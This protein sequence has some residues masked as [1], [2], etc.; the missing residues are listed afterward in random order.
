MILK[1]RIQKKL[2]LLLILS[3][4][5]PAD[6]AFA[7]KAYAQEAEEY[8]QITETAEGFLSEATD[9]AA[10]EEVQPN[11]TDPEVPVVGEKQPDEVT[12]PQNE[13]SKAEQPDEIPVLQNENQEM[14][15]AEQ[16]A[17]EDISAASGNEAEDRNKIRVII[18]RGGG[19]FKASVSGDYPAQ[20]RLYEKE[21]GVWLPGS[22]ELLRD[23]YTLKGFSLNQTKAE[24]GKIDTGC[25]EGYL[26]FMP[27]SVQEGDT[28]TFYPVWTGKTYRIRFDKNG[29]TGTV[30]ADIS[31]TCGTV[32][33]NTP[34][35]PNS[36]KYNLKRG[37]YD[38]KGWSESANAIKAK[39]ESG[40][41]LSS[42]TS[43]PNDTVL[44]AVFAPLTY[45]INYNLGV[46]DDDKLSGLL[47]NTPVPASQTLSGD[48]PVILGSLN[49]PEGYTFQGWYVKGT[50]SGT[51][52]YG[53][54]M[55]V[56]ASDIDFPDGA[57]VQTL[58]ANWM[59]D[60][61][62][63]SFTK[64]ITFQT[65]GGTE[66]RVDG[67]AVK[68]SGG[69]YTET[70][71]Y[72]LGSVVDL[73]R[74]RVYGKEN[75]IQD[76]EYG[77][78]IGGKVVQSGSVA[79]NADTTCTVNWVGENYT[80]HLSDAE[81][82]DDSRA[83]DN[84]DVRYGQTV[85][86][87]DVGKLYPHKGYQFSKWLLVNERT[88]KEEKITNLSGQKLSASDGDLP[89]SKD[90]HLYVRACWVPAKA[91]S[92]SPKPSRV[93]LESGKSAA[94]RFTVKPGNTASEV[95]YLSTDRKKDS[96]LTAL[97][98]EL[99]IASNGLVTLNLTV[100]S[101]K[102]GVEMV[103][104]AVPVDPSDLTKC[105]TAK[106]K[107]IVPGVGAENG[108]YVYYA[109]NGTRQKNKWADH[110]TIEQE[111]L[112]DALIYFDSAGY[113]VKTGWAKNGSKWS[114]VRNYE[115]IQEGFLSEGK[116]SD[117]T[118]AYYIENGLLKTGSFEATVSCANGSRKTF[119][120][121]SDKKTGA[122]ISG[123]VT[124]SGKQKY[125]GSVSAGEPYAD[126]YALNDSKE[127]PAFR[128]F[129]TKDGSGGKIRNYYDDTGKLF[130]PDAE[131]IYLLDGK[132]CYVKTDGDIP[133]NQ[134]IRSVP[135]RVSDSGTLKTDQNG[136][137]QTGVV[138][139]SDG[140]FYLT[141]EQLS[142]NTA[143]FPRYCLMKKT[144]A[145]LD[146]ATGKTCQ[147]LDKA[148]LSAGRLMYF[149]PDGKAFTGWFKKGSGIEG[150]TAFDYYNYAEKGVVKGLN[151][152][153]VLPKRAA[154]ST[155]K[156]TF[157]FE[158]GHLCVKPMV[159][160]I[161]KDKKRSYYRFTENGSLVAMTS[162][163]GASDAAYL[164]KW[165][166]DETGKRLYYVTDKGCYASGW[167][168]INGKYCYFDPDTNLVAVN[169]I[170]TISGKMY[171]FDGQ[172]NRIDSGAV[173]GKFYYLDD[174]KEN[175]RVILTVSANTDSTGKIKEKNFCFPAG[176]VD[177]KGKSLK[178]MAKNG[179]LIYGGNRFI[180]NGSGTIAPKGIYQVKINGKNR[181]YVVGNNQT[182]TM[183]AQSET[184]ILLQSGK[185][186]YCQS[187]S[188]VICASG[189][190]AEPVEV[191]LT[192]SGKPITVYVK[193][194]GTVICNAW[195]STGS[196]QKFYMTGDGTPAEGLLKV[197]GAWYFFKG[198][199][200]KTG[201]AGITLM[202]AA[203]KTEYIC[204]ADQ[205]GKISSGFR[206]R[207]GNTAALLTLYHT[208]SE[209]TVYLYRTD[210][211]GMIRTGTIDGVK[212]GAD[213]IYGILR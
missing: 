196:G 37:G 24:A 182:L 82:T 35:A 115:K 75:Y 126:R 154:G 19:V 49:S 176:T 121:C 139:L 172:G 161:L 28:L 22:D 164:N 70:D 69:A 57:A 44:Y 7:G 34:K 23:G 92:I 167:L 136:A 98:E 208:D 48:T 153:A 64:K 2:S 156:E 128:G 114:Y 180:L 61:A 46:G 122:L 43:R 187:E 90:H 190:A 211:N 30:P 168:L 118:P 56:R 4:L 11:E 91:K 68:L 111:G 120:F 52:Y 53:G 183:G 16:A 13:S 27:A 72:Y 76:P 93:V 26:Y 197:S 63:G 88:G 210:K 179:V 207:N 195:A 3:L 201:R 86:L 78:K 109:K 165:I 67:E 169:Q 206:D 80:V 12:E 175:N 97:P 198:G 177:A 144:D 119:S 89:D 166:T 151:G 117:Y 145:L 45:T 71:L 157:F 212:V 203:G 149:G 132:F 39:Y 5:I 96:L 191:R 204:T 17:P 25:S 193:S 138:T 178:G 81:D 140:I 200:P 106:I 9:P 142:A 87:P 123:W 95:V 32:P 42:L 194:N 141:P 188:G 199:L 185:N 104:A 112:K 41:D 54:G 192:P 158:N 146:A 15:V 14:S 137:V 73:T 173:E 38:F 83:Y 108:K 135:S 79:V 107:V 102:A 170:R 55:K 103:T 31:Y 40:D 181:K 6:I 58:Y 205:N 162:G 209:G 50:K 20:G 84:I 202:D 74:Y 184:P 94:V 85:K 147:A 124:N 189:S 134:E 127:A 105:K 51:R 159:R 1:R 133:V 100:S 116:D 171:A 65:D 174:S 143:A 113:A 130:Q 10:A 213:G 129:R 21:E 150:D 59:A 36:S 62:R 152:L 163:S 101:G 8:G 47:R 60:T 155:E 125:Y 131:G 33:K 18:E 160:V 29:G 110:I 186:C 66:L 77:W 99:P 148:V